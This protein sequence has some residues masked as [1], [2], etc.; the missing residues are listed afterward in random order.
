M[1]TGYPM[2]AFIRQHKYDPQ[3][4]MSWPT[5]AGLLE[6]ERLR[7]FFELLQGAPR[8]LIGGRHQLIL[9]SCL[10]EARDR[11]D[12]R[13]VM[14]LD[15]ELKDWLRLEMQVCQQDDRSG[16]MLGCQFSFPEVHLFGI[17]GSMSSWKPALFNT[18]ATRSA[19]SDYTIDFLIDALKDDDWKIRSSSASALGKQ[20]MLPESAIQSLI[21][22]L[23]HGDTR[24]S[25][26]AAW[27]LDAQSTLS[28]SAIQSLAASLKGDDWRVGSLAAYTLSRQSTLPESAV[29]S[30]TSALE[31]EDKRVRSLAGSVLGKD[32]AELF[33]QPPVTAL[34]DQKAK[35]V[36]AWDG[37]STLP[38]SDVESL[39]SGL[40][41][42]YE[43]VR[44]AAVSA[45][46]EDSR[47][48]EVAIQALIDALKDN[49]WSV[50]FSAVS[51][52]DCQSRLPESAIQSL[53]DTLMDSNKLVRSSAAWTL[54]RQS[55][56]SESVIQRLILA[57]GGDDKDVRLS[58]IVILGQQST[59]PMAAVR[60][61]IDAFKDE[62]IEFRR[63]VSE[64]LW[65][66]Y[67]S[68]FTALPDLT[69]EEMASLYT[70]RLFRYSCSR[71]FSLHVEDGRLWICTEKGVQFL[72]T[73]GTDLE[74]TIMSAVGDVQLKA[75]LHARKILLVP[76][77]VSSIAPQVEE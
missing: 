24:R 47:L 11:L 73:T 46:G 37:Q 16:S 62:D 53:S 38:D 66:H 39:I 48:P 6:G 28:E 65:D 67:D 49:S 32:C 21:D 12:S 15:E 30:L 58:V 54:R 64:A 27:V 52:L 7:M 45:L 71:V 72:E 76:D 56:F 3:F 23:E 68:L 55:E 29:Q 51:A 13:I 1:M 2:V 34:I 70:N 22:A 31:D 26:L 43:D 35:V 17:L 18:L 40:Q 74:Q 33:I 57:L 41:D 75:G 20:F 44:S 50:G 14:D 5:I 8:D 59:L 25:H 63:S 4:E 42:K 77:A 61:L 19:L 10:N 9:A 36:S 69:K 60:F